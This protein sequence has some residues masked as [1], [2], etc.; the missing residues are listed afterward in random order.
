MCPIW[1]ARTTPSAGRRP[2]QPTKNTSYHPPTVLSPAVGKAGVSPKEHQDLA[3]HSTYALTS[4]YTHSR[5]Y[6]LAAAVQSLPI[7]AGLNP[8]TLA[9]TG[10]DGR[11]KYLGPNLGPQSAKTGDFGRQPEAHDN[12]LSQTKN[13]G[14][15]A[16]FGVFRGSDNGLSKVEAAGVEPASRG[17][18]APASTC[19]ASLSRTARTLRP[20]C[21]VRRPAL[22]RAGLPAN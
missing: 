6:D 4:R 3:R 2:S 17:T 8:Q 1:D 12:G 7:P 13:P 9:A 11:Q 16:V 19:V 18:S 10:T 14:K 5:L 21:P 22:R 20:R 15:P